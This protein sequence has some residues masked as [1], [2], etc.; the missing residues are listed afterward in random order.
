MGYIII[1]WRIAAYCD[2]MYYSCSCKER[3][4]EEGRDIRSAAFTYLVIESTRNRKEHDMQR[5]DNYTFISIAY[6][7]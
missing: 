4:K 2:V 6:Y 3:K 1:L 5:L 7:A